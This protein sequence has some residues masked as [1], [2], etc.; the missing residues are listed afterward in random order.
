MLKRILPSQS[1]FNKFLQAYLR[2]RSTASHFF[3]KKESVI[4]LNMKNIWRKNLAVFH[5]VEKIEIYFPYNTS[6]SY[7]G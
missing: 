4:I 5:D 7:I 1:K 2:A 3:T 6:V